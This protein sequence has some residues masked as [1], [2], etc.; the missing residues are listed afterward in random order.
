MNNDPSIELG[1]FS[2]AMHLSAFFWGRNFEFHTPG[3]FF[4]AVHTQKIYF[5]EF[6]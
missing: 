2:T 5:P 4:K 3:S 6:H 1:I